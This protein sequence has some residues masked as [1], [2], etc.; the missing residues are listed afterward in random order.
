MVRFPSVF[1]SGAS[2][3]SW[4]PILSWRER[5]EGMARL[6]AA[7]ATGDS[8]AVELLAYIRTCDRMSGPNHGR[9][10]DAKWVECINPT[11]TLALLERRGLVKR[12]ERRGLVPRFHGI[13]RLTDKGREV[14]Q[15]LPQDGRRGRDREMIPA[16]PDLGL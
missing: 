13:A 6:K 4:W 7:A 11:R 3:V 15:G 2:C 12:I 9:R 10:R 5:E 8:Y 16:T 1:P 14:A